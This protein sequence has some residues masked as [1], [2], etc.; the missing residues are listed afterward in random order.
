[1]EL[2]S[3]KFKPDV[4]FLNWAPKVKIKGVEKTPI[5]SFYGAVELAQKQ[6]RR[7]SGLPGTCVVLV[8]VP[9]ATTTVQGHLIDP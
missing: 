9:R 3:T 7:L 1:M 8:E 2:I 5:K 4:L 6:Q